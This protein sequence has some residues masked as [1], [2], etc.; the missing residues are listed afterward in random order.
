MEN[1]NEVFGKMGV[2]T[3]EEKLRVLYI[4]YAVREIHLRDVGKWD[5]PHAILDY[6]S[7]VETLAGPFPGHVT[8]R[9]PGPAK[10]KDDFNAL[11][12]ILQTKDI[13]L[14]V[15]DILNEE[16][17]KRAHFSECIVDCKMSGALF[18]LYR[19]AVIQ[20]KG[21][22]NNNSVYEC[23]SHLIVKPVAGLSS[24][25]LQRILKWFFPKSIYNQISIVHSMAYLSRHITTALPGL[26]SNTDASKLLIFIWYSLCKTVFEGTAWE[27]PSAALL[28]D[29]KAESRFLEIVALAK[30]VFTF[31]KI[32]YTF[33][34]LYRRMEPLDEKYGMANLLETFVPGICSAGRAWRF[35]GKMDPTEKL[36]HLFLAVCT[37]ARHEKCI[38]N[39][40]RLFADPLPSEDS[41]SD[42][43]ML[44]NCVRYYSVEPDRLPANKA[45]TDAIDI[46]KQ[47]GAE[48]PSVAVPLYTHFS[49]TYFEYKKKEPYLEAITS[50]D[51]KLT[52]TFQA[53]LKKKRVN[54][55]DYLRRIQDNCEDYRAENNLV[56]HDFATYVH[57]KANCRALIVNPNY[58]FIRSWQSD[59]RANLGCSSTFILSSSEIAECLSL[60]FAA[61]NSKR[62]IESITLFRSLAELDSTKQFDCILYFSRGMDAGQISQVLG[63]CVSALKKEGQLLTILPDE[64]VSVKSAGEILGEL[65]KTKDIII[66]PMPLTLA[67]STPKKKLYIKSMGISTDGGAGTLT[68]G[69]LLLINSKTTTNCFLRPGES[70]QVEAYKLFDTK[71]VHVRALLKQILQQPAEGSR[72]EPEVFKFSDEISIY[73]STSYISSENRYRATVYV[74]EVPDSNRR[75]RSKLHR[76][77]KIRASEILIR[78]ASYEALVEKIEREAPFR[79]KL[80]HSAAEAVTGAFRSGQLAD[81]SLKTFWYCYEKQ[82][83]GRSG[84][85]ETLTR[86]LIL[87]RGGE[88]LSGCMLNMTDLEEY[89]A[90][91]DKLFR[92]EKIA[93]E[94]ER[95]RLWRQ[96]DLILQEAVN[97]NY[98]PGNN[99]VRAFV[100]TLTTADKSQEVRDALVKKSLEHTEESRLLTWIE[101]Q[102]ERCNFPVLG[103]AIRL[104]TG[105]EPEEVCALTWKDYVNITHIDSHTFYVSKRADNKGNYDLPLPT[106]ERYRIVPIP[107]TLNAMIKIMLQYLRKSQGL[108]RKELV[109]RGQNIVSRIDESGRTFPCTPK[110]IR[111][112]SKT[113]LTT[114]AGIAS[115]LITLP[116]SKQSDMNQYQGD[117]FR[118]NFRYRA[119]ETCGLTLGELS[120]VLG[121]QPSDTFSR[122]YC[123]YANDLSQLGIL[124]KLARWIIGRDTPNMRPVI[125][126]YTVSQ[127]Y[128][129]QTGALGD[130][131]ASM[132]IQFEIP[133]NCGHVVITVNSKYGVRGNA[134]YI[135]K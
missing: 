112:I 105:M 18:A 29:S 123:D 102:M 90:S 129:I 64:F 80:R 43:D 125:E 22:C 8:K 111:K 62:N 34:R 85:S 48:K 103:V 92:Q 95:V 86:L 27:Y 55:I 114:G 134:T 44:L 133:A 96:L 20:A 32:K 10:W 132:D 97:E 73:Y 53:A 33:N 65:L 42:S 52:E 120:Y 26:E 113:A 117:L 4:A 46:L 106:K 119:L 24:E 94:A 40:A 63:Q 1:L 87:S 99:P 131:N 56:Y 37:T 6:N 58:E 93:S 107:S 108:T 101:S 60:D 7:S 78:D 121:V 89:K 35:L 13:D 83:C 28:T 2:V 124:I 110:E 21:K 30:S 82:L 41:D 57:E 79:G 72:K 15:A 109:D 59:I 14:V 122:H 76:G 39:L 130:G 54:A 116:S 118:S 69:E 31:A 71:D 75:K 135:K 11:Y 3:S 128:I 9:S 38:S 100:K 25:Q 16:P 23:Y 84:F 115:N 47:S 61:H 70:R 66:H 12:E 51:Y 77:K 88:L 36:V 74:C 68:L 17:G 98:I 127:D 19:I 50:V 45:V 91:M 126:E 67:Q 49:G 5:Y 81:I 104:F